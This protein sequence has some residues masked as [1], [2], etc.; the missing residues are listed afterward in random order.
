MDSAG[1]SI[2]LAA[3]IGGTFTDIASFDEKTGRLSFGKKLS[4]PDALVDGIEAGV[5]EADA[6][7]ADANLFL[8]GTTI[9]INTILERT[10]AK[11][12]LVITEGFRDV[13]EIGRVNRPDAYN[14]F[15]K[16]HR[17]LVE[18]ALRFEVNERMYAE[19]EVYRP[20]LDAEV[21]ALAERLGAMDIEATAIL[22]LHSY[23]N[24]D[25]E[26]RA[27]AIF[28][29]LNPAMFVT[30]SHELSQEYREFER[31]STVAANAY[32]GPKVR[33][34][35][36]GIEERITGEGFGGSFLVVQS[37]GGLY[38]VA[39]AKSD[40]VHMLES[41]PAAGVIGTKALCDT[42]EIKDAIS[43]DMGGTTAKSGVISGGAPLTTGSALVGGYDQALPIQVAMMDIAEVGTGGGSIAH[44][45][46]GGSLRIGP[47]SAGAR[48]GPVCYGL[49][50]TEPTVTDA[51]LVLGRLAADRF[52][53]GDM[54]LDLGAAERAI[55][56]RIA[57]PL[58]MDV[59]AAADGI[60]KI[61]ATAMSYAVKAVST[62]RGL[63][64]ASFA[65]V[66]FGGAGP[67]H[68]S[69]VA[70]EIG[71]GRIIVPQAPGHF[72]AFGMLFSDLRY[73][74]V[75][76]HPMRLADADFANIEPIYAEMEDAGRAAILRTSVNAGERT[77]Q[78]AADMRYVGQEHAVTVELPLALFETQDR[79]G[80]K[81]EFDR[82]HEI[83]YGTS[84]PAEQAEI[85]S[86]RSA[87]TGAMQK[88]PLE[89]IAAGAE[90]PAE[91]ARTGSRRI[92]FSEAGEFVE[93][94]A[95]DRTHLK[96][97]NRI[98]GPAVIDEHASTTLAA[99]GDRV[100][101]DAYGNLLISAHGVT[102]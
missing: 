93:T 72:S 68:A 101:V 37:T 83:R 85:V 50:G 81:A 46:D 22:F 78:R 3:D 23:R 14:L 54:K 74:Y 52:L 17:P 96:A 24:P 8:H 62:E 31:A 89:P 95:F 45:S 40:C 33:S 58:G 49:G 35:L 91:T 92:Y 51:N 73:D 77:V 65:M 70:R 1:P 87:V 12:A 67:L 80:I 11:T 25:H 64:A 82:V 20:L 71:M 69:D 79:D 97:G 15:F 2:R 53:G 29:R 56:E 18:R 99:P 19:G 34:Y 38:E 6:G 102:E 60:L 90:A 66:A 26:I 39:Q 10:G 4:T 76:T 61:A 13:Y 59:I 44:L 75:R 57:D 94:P 28:E 88:P 43:F 21:E 100:S 7:F 63:D 41:G 27:K 48:P 9:A 47:E 16:K 36:S 32:I 5:Q 55:K 84:A 98:D 30:V 42:L 86:L